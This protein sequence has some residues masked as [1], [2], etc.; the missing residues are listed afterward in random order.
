MAAGESALVPVSTED[1]VDAIFAKV[2]GTGV[3]S[4]QLLVP[5]NTAALQTPR[6]FERLA[7]RL[8]AAGV[9][10]LVISSDAQTL[11]AARR[12]QVLTMAVQGARVQTP[13]GATPT[14]YT[15]QVL[16]K[17]PAS[18]GEADFLNA[19]DQVPARDRYADLP[20]VDADLYA[21]LDELPPPQTRGSSTRPST[22]SDDDFAASLDEWSDMSAGATASDRDL[23]RAAPPRRYSVDDVDLS[24]DDLSRQR[25]G[26][27][28]TAQRARA[29]S[30]ATPTRGTTGA[31]RRAAAAGRAY[32][33]DLDD[34][35]K[36][37]RSSARLLLPLAVLALIVLAAVYWFASSRTTV[38][39]TFS[40]GRP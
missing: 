34:Y 15:T 17:T 30:R 3:A 35:P 9:Q 18:K 4:V 19:L 32:E 6:G 37:R 22:S 29:E 8:E 25:G 7:R 33:D 26:R 39:R 16:P 36:A 23:E 14:R 11:D 10:L 24:D 38:A 31:R 1:T 28:T 13:P 5:D 21:A 27:R 20:D 2:R 40:F 12:N